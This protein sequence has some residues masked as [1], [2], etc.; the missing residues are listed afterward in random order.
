MQGLFY[1][2]VWK[3]MTIRCSQGLYLELYDHTYVISQ[4]NTL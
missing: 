4:Q 2:H 3:M 1:I